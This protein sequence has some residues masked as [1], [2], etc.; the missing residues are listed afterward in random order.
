MSRGKEHCL[1]KR[2][3]LDPHPPPWRDVSP[4]SLCCDMNQGQFQEYETLP[5]SVREEWDRLVATLL[6]IRK[7]RDA[8]TAYNKKLID[9]INENASVLVCDPF[10]NALIFR[11]FF[12]RRFT[13]LAL[14][15]LMTSCFAEIIV[16][17]GQTC[18]RERQGAEV[19]TRSQ[20]G[21]RQGLRERRLRSLTSPSRRG[22]PFHG[23]WALL[24]CRFERSTYFGSPAKLSD[25]F[26]NLVCT[27]LTPV[28]R[29]SL[30]SSR[31]W[32]IRIHTER[33]RR[34]N[35]DLIRM[36]SR[37]GARDTTR[38]FGAALRLSTL[39]TAL[40]RR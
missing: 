18:G 3:H 4:A 30:A 34:R 38:S 23:P 29:F 27:L 24:Q 8:V 26:D 10:S 28:C 9:A 7:A 39:R 19:E 33:R 5:P 11:N 2:S 13:F 1:R 36:L 37:F 20:A 16:R 22:I 17:G 21:R 35:S 15:E 12:F 31:Y 40:I 14:P 32:S 6:N 25:F